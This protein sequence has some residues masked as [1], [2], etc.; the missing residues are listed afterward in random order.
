MNFDGKVILITGASSGIGADAARHLADL[1]GNVVIV[2]RNEKRLNEVAQEIK[3]NGSPEPLAIVADVIV[4]G[5]R[6]IDEAIKH[7][8]QLDVLVNNAGIST[9]DDIVDFKIE[10]FDRIFNTNVRSVATLTNLA[11]S[12]LEKTK[13]NIVN[14][15]SVAGLKAVP[16]VLSY[17][18]SKSSIDML[19]RCCALDLASRGIRVNAINPAVIKTPIFKTLGISTESIEKHFEL[20]KQKYPVGRVGEVSDTSAAIAYLASESASFITGTLLPVDGGLMI[21]S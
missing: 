5:K 12:H 11:V 13:G 18:M 8:G 19:T 2:G 6:I 10:E 7:F 1:G 15:S 17:C 21:S 4:D 3:N 14:V 9:Q 16:N 20:M